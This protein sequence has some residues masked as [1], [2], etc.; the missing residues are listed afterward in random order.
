LYSSEVVLAIIPIMFDKAN[1]VMFHS[2]I[3]FYTMPVTI[4]WS[5][6]LVE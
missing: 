3:L 4:S 1:T 6:S 5:W 2:A